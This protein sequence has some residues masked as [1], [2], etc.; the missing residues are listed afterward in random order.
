MKELFVSK[1]QEE[2]VKYLKCCFGNL[3][4]KKYYALEC[5]DTFKAFF[6][7]FDSVAN[8]LSLSQSKKTSTFES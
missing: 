5:V 7:L 4:G 1:A 3:K 8:C 6:I 2:D